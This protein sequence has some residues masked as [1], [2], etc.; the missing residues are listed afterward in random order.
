MVPLRDVSVDLSA[1][2]LLCA[3]TDRGAVEV[4]TS[5][6]KRHVSVSLCQW[7]SLCRRG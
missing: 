2:W 6:P 5:G 1:T 4:E 7:V 3:G